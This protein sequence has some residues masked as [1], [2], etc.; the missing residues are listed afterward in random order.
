M[1]NLAKTT[2]SPGRDTKRNVS[3]NN[4]K[5]TTTTVIIISARALRGRA[6]SLAGL[7]CLAAW[8][9]GAPIRGEEILSAVA[10]E[11]QLRE[12]I[13]PGNHGA[14]TRPWSARPRH[15]AARQTSARPNGTN[16]RASRSLGWS[17]GRYIRNELSRALSQFSGAPLGSSCCSQ[18]PFAAVGKPRAGAPNEPEIKWTP[19]SR[20]G[21][22]SRCNERGDALGAGNRPLELCLAGPRSCSGA[23]RG[24]GGLSKLW[25]LWGDDDLLWAETRSL[26]RAPRPSS[27]R[28]MATCANRAHNRVARRPIKS[29]PSERHGSR[30]R[31]LCVCVCARAIGQTNCLGSI[32]SQPAS[33]SG[34]SERRVRRQAAGAVIRRGGQ[35]GRQRRRREWL[36]R[37]GG[38]K[39]KWHFLEP[40]EAGPFA[41]RR[42]PRPA[43]RVL[44]EM[45]E[46]QPL[47]C[48]RAGRTL[49]PLFSTRSLA[50]S[51]ACWREVNKL[52]W[53][54]CRL[55][56]PSGPPPL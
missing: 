22:K 16:S 2:N 21:P 6:R 3:R 52:V 32:G 28:P 37:G 48:E 11:C 36:K 41:A 4:K 38:I 31:P 23:P 10:I 20:R 15:Q 53:P 5:T 24:F 50:R 40:A 14:A 42:R 19:P 55:A 43:A 54:V 13:S 56:R 25:S 18:R 46:A 51:L 35:D 39:P 49:C 34:P 29:A 26:S 9:G 7:S 17:R 44:N 8:I 30:S 27:A 47:V 33:G 45:R 12:K 1:N